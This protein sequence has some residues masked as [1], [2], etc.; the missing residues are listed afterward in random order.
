VFQPPQA[1]CNSVRV[2]AYLKSFID[3]AVIFGFYKWACWKI[4]QNE[5]GR[6]MDIE[7]I[8]CLLDPKCSL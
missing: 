5:E 6:A 8:Q 2:E 7:G 1:K 4:N 3:A